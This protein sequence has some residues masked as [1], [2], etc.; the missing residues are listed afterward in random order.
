MSVVVLNHAIVRNHIASIHRQGCR[1]IEREQREHSSNIYGPFDNVEDAIAD[2][3]D[4]ELVEMGYDR[5]DLKIHNCAK[6]S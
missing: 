2:Y 6:G 4:D 5:A 3:L 1:D